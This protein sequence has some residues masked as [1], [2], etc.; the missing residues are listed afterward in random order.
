MDCRADSNAKERCLISCVA[1]ERIAG[2][3]LET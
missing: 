2:L 1:P 3:M